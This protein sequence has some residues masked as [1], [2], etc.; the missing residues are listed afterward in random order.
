MGQEKERERERENERRIREIEVCRRRG[1]RSH[2]QRRVRKRKQG[3]NGWKHLHRGKPHQKR[4]GR[5]VRKT[6]LRTRSDLPRFVTARHVHHN[7]PP[8][9]TF[10]C[11]HSSSGS[12]PPHRSNTHFS[13]ALLSFFF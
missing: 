5:E 10:P 3:R 9:S 2:A 12:L 6:R 4:C 1:A 13:F 11:A 7:L 8:P